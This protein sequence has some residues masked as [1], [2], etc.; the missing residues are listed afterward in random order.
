[1]TVCASPATIAENT[2]QDDRVFA[3]SAPRLIPFMVI[4]YLLA[5]LDRVNVGFAALTMNRDLSFSPTVFG[6][7]AGV[8]FL[9]FLLFQVPA[10]LIL[11]RIGARRWIAYIV[12]AWGA[13]SAAGALVQNPVAFYVLRFLLGVAEAGFSPGMIFYLTL[14][15]PQAYRARF[16][17]L[18]MTAIPLSYIIG[19]PVSTAILE[20]DGLAGLHGWQ[21]L[22]LIEGLPACALAL[23][24]PKLMP[25]GPAEASWLDEHEKAMIATRLAAEEAAKRSDFFPTLLDL[26]VLMLCL[27]SFGAGFGGAGVALWLPQIVQS[28]GYSNLEVGWVVSLFALIG[29]VTMIAWGRSSDRR[30]ERV[31]HV[32]LPLLI[33]A[34]AL[35]VASLPFAAAISLIALG[36]VVVGLF[37]IDG[38]FFSLPSAFLSGSAVAGGIALINSVGSLGSFL[39]P[40]LI[41]VLRDQTGSYS[42]GMVALAVGLIFAAT[43]VLALGRTMT[44]RSALQADH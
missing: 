44:V 18:F 33:A 1:M 20:L 29:M 12:M 41:G 36:C 8:F 38:P 16:T 31:W 21:W 30:N 25:N 5:W 7:G 11:A 6:F 23:L 9:G 26:R 22:F 15:F 35:L 19:A 10:N 42:E 17:A 14:W 27:V 2:M 4:L 43:A 3:R 28:M 24:V 37:A 40:V 34:A 13:I 32:S 39:G